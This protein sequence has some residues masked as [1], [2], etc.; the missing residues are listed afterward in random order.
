MNDPKS[1]VYMDE[2]PED[3]DLWGWTGPGWY[4]LIDGGIEIDGPFQS[5]PDAW[6]ALEAER[7]AREDYY[8]SLDGPE[9]DWDVEIDEEEEDGP[10]L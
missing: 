9:E 5:E 10:W 3:N 2:A 1:V 8:Q 4:F 7:A 6:A